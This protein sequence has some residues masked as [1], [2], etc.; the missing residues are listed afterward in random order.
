MARFPQPEAEKGSQK[1]VQKLVND[2]PEILNSR[3]WSSLN[4][5]EEEHI[6]WLSPLKGDDYAEYR[7][8]AFLNLLDVKLEKVPLAQFWPEGG[9]Q[10]DALGKSS[11]GKLLLVEA[12]SHISELI[13]SLQAEDQGS[14][15][16]ITTSLGETKR[17]LNSSAQVEWTRC[18]YQHANRLAHLYLLRKNDLHAYLI[19]VYFLNDIEM[20]GPTSLAEWE[21]ALRLLKSA[22]GIGRHKLQKFITNVYVD[23]RA[24][25]V[26]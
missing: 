5:S 2:K 1:W 12:K 16:K 26:T 23:V 17:Y 7:D 24:L 18:F 14:I 19:F 11:S 22:L 9:P 10:W 13:S 6:T 3:I 25:Q 8:Q 4:F 20:K 21:G 15:E